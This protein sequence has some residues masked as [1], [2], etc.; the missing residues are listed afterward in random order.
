MRYSL[1]LCAMLIAP[2]LV[3]PQSLARRI[4]DAHD[5]VASFTFD[6]RPGVCGNGRD[7]LR[8]GFGDG[9]IISANFNGYTH[10]RRWDDECETGPVRVVASLADG[11]VV[12]LRTYAGPIMHESD[13]VRDLGNVPVRDA[14]AFLT[15]LVNSGRGRVADEAMLPLVLADGPAPWPS[16]FRIARNENQSRSVRRSAATWLS[17]AAVAKLGIA[18]REETDDDE[19]RSSAVFA[20]SQQRDRAVP[21][22]LS[23]ARTSTHPA[24]R[25]Q[26]LFW[27][28]QTGDLRAIDYFAEILGE[29]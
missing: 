13:R 20:L 8:D 4:A 26:A 21:E 7:F 14:T 17:R 24:A 2:R 12:S 19:V 18:G 6:A 9:R 22:L 23:V 29:R 15:E 11:E 5:G 1:G 16:F 3:S 10:D 28:G 27:L 25:A